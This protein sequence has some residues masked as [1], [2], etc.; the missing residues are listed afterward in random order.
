MQSELERRANVLRRNWM[1]WGGKRPSW[2][3]RV[4]SL[5]NYWGAKRAARKVIQH[6][7]TDLAKVNAVHPS[8][9]A[10][11]GQTLLE[12]SEVEPDTF[13]RNVYMAT[14]K[15]Q[16]ELALKKFFILFQQDHSPTASKAIRSVITQIQ[17]ILSGEIRPGEADL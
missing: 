7:R 13:L 6:L 2:F 17:R 8:A 1:L 4:K 11:I 12:M 14:G 10:I 9:N 16:L 3:S 5:S 15:L